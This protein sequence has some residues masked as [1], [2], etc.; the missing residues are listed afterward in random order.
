MKIMQKVVVFS[1]LAVLCGCDNSPMG[2][3]KSGSLDPELGK[4]WAAE[5][6]E[7]SD[8]WQQAS[9]YCK[10]KGSAIYYNKKPNCSAVIDEYLDS[11]IKANINLNRHPINDPF[12]K[13]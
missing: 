4:S 10:A 8:L 7:N 5:R 3:L 11:E 9:I 6:Q 12:D 2:K 13:K 1:V